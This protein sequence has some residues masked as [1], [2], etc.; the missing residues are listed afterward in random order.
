MRLISNELQFRISEI[1]KRCLFS[2]ID[3]ENGDV[4]LISIIFGIFLGI[5]CENF[6]GSCVRVR[7]V[8][9]DGMLQVCD[10]RREVVFVVLL[11]QGA[12]PGAGPGRVRQVAQRVGVEVVRV[13]QPAVN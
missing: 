7:V 5:F 1:T 3:V 13:A 11:R 6:L 8:L 2:K 12:G 4:F 9:S 10:V